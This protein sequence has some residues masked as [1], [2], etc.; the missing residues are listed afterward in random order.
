MPNTGL[1]VISPHSECDKD[2][3]SGLVKL[4]RSNPNRRDLLD[5][6][7]GWREIAAD[8]YKIAND[9]SD[10]DFQDYLAASN[11]ERAGKDSSDEDY[12]RFAPIWAPEVILLCA[13][14]ARQHDVSWGL[15]Y[16]RLKSDGTIAANPGSQG[17]YVV[18]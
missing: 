11:L 5:F 8:A 6:L 10:E 4:E 1:V 14:F 7:Q 18:R 15:A 3:I 9:M 12:E 13:E 17:Y 2:Y 16:Q